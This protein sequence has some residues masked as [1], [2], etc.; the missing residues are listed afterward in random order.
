MKSDLG[1]SKDVVGICVGRAVREG[2]V[3]L[4]LTDRGILFSLKLIFRVV[5]IEHRVVDS[6]Q[7]I[8]DIVVPILEVWWNN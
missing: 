1:N 5:L 3:Q 8:A 7:E 6:N 2:K 4:I